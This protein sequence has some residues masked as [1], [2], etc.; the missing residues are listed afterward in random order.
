MR[1]AYE[2]EIAQEPDIVLEALVDGTMD[3]TWT[4]RE[5]AKNELEARAL[6]YESHAAI[7]EARAA[8]D[9]RYP[10]GLVT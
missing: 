8:Y 4:T 3:A 6:A 7:R 9:R 10:E 5:L 1:D 2:S